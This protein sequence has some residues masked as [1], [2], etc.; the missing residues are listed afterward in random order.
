MFGEE[1]LFRKILC[2]VKEKEG[3]YSHFKKVGKLFHNKTLDMIFRSVYLL[4]S[5]IIEVKQK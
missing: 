5:I 3:V 4:V 1:N 2:K